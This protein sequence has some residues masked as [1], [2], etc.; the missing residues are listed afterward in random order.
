MWR[1]CGLVLPW[2]SRTAK[3]LIQLLLIR[4]LQLCPL[5]FARLVCRGAGN[6]GGALRI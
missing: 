1:R 3:D 6:D 4:M 2:S 5:L